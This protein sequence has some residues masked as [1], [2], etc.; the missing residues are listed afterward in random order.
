[1]KKTLLLT[2]LATTVVAACSQSPAATATPQSETA[3]VRTIS[4][5]GRVVP[6][7]WATLSTEGG[8][9]VTRV[10]VAR[11]DAVEAGQT[12]AE[13]G[14]IERLEAALAIAE[15]EYI[16]ASQAL[17]EL[18]A[19]AELVLGQRQMAMAN[20]RRQAEDF[21]TDAE[22]ASQEDYYKSALLEA[23]AWLAKASARYDYLRSHDASAIE[24]AAA[25]QEYLKAMQS[26][27]RA[28]AT[29]ETAEPDTTRV[30]L[31]REIRIARYQEALANL[32]EAERLYERVKDGQADPLLLESAQ[33]RLASAEKA[34]AAARVSLEARTIRAPFAGTVGTVYVREGELAMPGQPVVT[35]GDL[36][37][38]RVETTDL[39]EIDVARLLPGQ[40]AAVSLDALPERMLEGRVLS[41]SP[42]AEPGSGAVTFTVVVELL[43]SDPVMRWGMTAF[44]D[45][46]DSD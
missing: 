27:Q 1:M 11:G 19:G 33:A 15:A 30:H 29:Y 16:A 36:S 24:T 17:D 4:A 20:A 41:I 6:E 26:V 23:E 38:M 14:S 18:N 21:K 9:L 44:V 7:R 39:D 32:A 45:I 40:P 31:N 3:F 34:R 42:M 8:G 12:L 2:I 13:I 22:I 37:S 25:Y 46:T 28:Q 5:S 10:S 43:E 35:L